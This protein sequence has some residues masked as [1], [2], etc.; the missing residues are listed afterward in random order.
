MD[1]PTIVSLAG[2]VGTSMTGLKTT[3]EIAQNIKGLVG[4]PDADVTATKQLVSEL[5]DRLIQLQTEHVAMQR[6]IADVLEEQRR[7][8]QFQAETERYALK[9]TE[10]GALV[11]ELKDVD[12]S[13]EAAHCICAT[14][15]EKQ[16][17]SILQPVG[18]NTLGCNICGGRFLKPDGQS[19]GIMVASTRRRDFDGFI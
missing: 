3:T 19:S 2:L 17:K 14:C 11:Y 5:L 13:G 4:K 12:A 7:T 8:D 16:V 15:Y 1:L 9:R 6:A 10:L 18:R